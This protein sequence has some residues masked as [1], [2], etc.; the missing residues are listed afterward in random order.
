M[1]PKKKNAAKKGND[2]WEAEAL[3]DAP[4]APDAAAS[5]AAVE[6]DAPAGGGGLMNLMRKNKEKRKKKGLSED[7]AEGET[8]PGAT[9]EVAEIEAKAPVEANLD[10]EFALPDKKGKGKQL[11]GK[12]QEEDAKA[13]EEGDGSGKVLTKAEKEK[14]KKEKEKQRKKELV[15]FLARRLD[16][17]W[18]L[19][20]L[21][22]RLRR[23]R[24]LA[25]LNRPRRSLLR[26][27]LSRRRTMLRLPLRS[28]MPV[29]KRRSSRLTCW[30]F[31]NSRRICVANERRRSASR[32]RRRPE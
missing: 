4:A 2:D 22:D 3:G 6:E 19:I 31:R 30:R 9:D 26:R 7:F 14:L 12:K 5:P 11:A 23:R 24:L 21:L 18:M 25:G 29:G 1:A 27:L 17:G 16:A 20:W 10:D 8:A 28:L 32:P 13:D 15:S